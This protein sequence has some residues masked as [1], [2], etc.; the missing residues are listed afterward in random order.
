MY[1]TAVLWRLGGIAQGLT[2][3]DEDLW[4]CMKQL[5][6]LLV[7][8][9]PPAYRRM[10]ADE[11]LKTYRNHRNVFTHVR[12]VADLSFADA[13]SSHRDPSHLLD[14]LRLSTFYVAV[15]INERLSGI[16]PETVR[17]WLDVVEKDQGWVN[18]VA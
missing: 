7:G 14:Y 6:R 10:T 13:L 9:L 1:R 12:P 2:G 11:W 15:S 5:N 16:D 17:R 18:T 4:G 3:G 8:S